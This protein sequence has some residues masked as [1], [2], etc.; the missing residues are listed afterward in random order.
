MAVTTALPTAPGGGVNADILNAVRSGAADN[1]NVLKNAG[2]G[3]GTAKFRIPDAMVKGTRAPGEKPL[4]DF[5]QVMSRQTYAEKS[6]LASIRE[7]ALYPVPRSSGP[8]LGRGRRSL[9]QGR[10]DA[11]T[12]LSRRARGRTARFTI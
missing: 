2:I 4:D 8:R 9:R 10:Q 5:D 7:E 3:S 1:T 6:F 12:P 11:R